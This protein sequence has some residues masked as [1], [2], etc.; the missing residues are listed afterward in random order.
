MGLSDNLGYP[1]RGTLVGDICYEQ[2]PGGPPFRGTPSLRSS[3][4]GSWWREVPCRGGCS[5]GKGRSGGALGDL[6]RGRASCLHSSEENTGA[7]Q[8]FWTSCV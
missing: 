7:G 1:P 2:A 3:L 5:E 8:W 4:G 6:L